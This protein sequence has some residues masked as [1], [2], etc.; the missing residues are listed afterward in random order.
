MG[1]VEFDATVV[2]LVVR[3]FHK[4]RY[5]DT[6]PF[7]AA[8]GPSGVVRSVFNRAEQGFVGGVVVAH[9]WPGNGP[10]HSQPSSLD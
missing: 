3:P 9:P 10:E 6:S 7:L 5:P 1:R 2:V 8:K 4:C